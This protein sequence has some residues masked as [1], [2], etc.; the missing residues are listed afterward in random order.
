MSFPFDRRHPAIASSVVS[1]IC[2]YSS[3][4]GFANDWHLVHLGSRAVG[5]AAVVFTEAAAVT[6]DGRISAHDLGIRKDEQVEFLSR[7]ARFV[8][9]QGAGMQI[10]HA[11]RKGSTP[12][13]WEG[14]G[15]VL[16]ARGGWH[17]V[18]P[19]AV[20]FDGNYSIP[21]AGCLPDSGHR[22]ILRG[23]RPPS[24]GDRIPGAR[25]PAA[26]VASTRNQLLRLGQLTASVFVS[27]VVLPRYWL[28]TGKTSTMFLP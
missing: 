13:P 2:Q 7:I 25:N 18:A 26:A 3:M 19:S 21:R 8:R 11:G 17:T 16:P 14:T 23:C 10:A 24:L 28:A 6:P 1:P 15:T 5:G 27:Q 20:P 22:R 4:D 12:R 9:G